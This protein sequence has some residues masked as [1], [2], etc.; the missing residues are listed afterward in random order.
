MV[1]LEGWGSRPLAAGCGLFWL[2]VVPKNCGTDFIST[3]IPNI[4]HPLAPPESSLPQN[5]LSSQKQNSSQGRKRTSQSK[6]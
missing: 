3:T 5:H 4:T 6:T 2:A 1:D